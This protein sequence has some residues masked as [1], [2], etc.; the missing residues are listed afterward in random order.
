M[1]ISTDTKSQDTKGAFNIIT[2]RPKFLHRSPQKRL[3]L[4]W[5]NI[6]LLRNISS[7]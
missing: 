2:N 3:K 7:I 1:S 4:I 5:L 6:H